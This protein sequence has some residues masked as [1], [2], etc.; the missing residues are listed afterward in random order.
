MSLLNESKWSEADKKAVWDMAKKCDPENEALGFR[1]DECGA[2]IK[3]DKYGDR[4]SD[5]GW[6]IDHIKAVANGGNESLN[7]LR[8][9]HWKNNAVKQDG[10]LTCPVKSNGAKN[11]GL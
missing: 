10:R 4:S 1:K 2:W 11:T 7:N 5:Y 6:E 3:W 9:L 8:P